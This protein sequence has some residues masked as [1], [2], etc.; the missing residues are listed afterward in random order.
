MTVFTFTKTVL[1]NTAEADALKV[2]LPLSPGILTHA[3][4]NIPFGVQFFC[5]FQILDGLLNV[6]PSR[7]GQYY[8]GEGPPEQIPVWYHLKKEPFELIWKLWNVD[9]TYPHTIVLKLVVLT[10]EEAASLDSL[11]KIIEGLKGLSEVLDKKQLPVL[12]ELVKEMKNLSS[13]LQ[14]TKK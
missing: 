4:V 2:P 13:R 8:T 10:E 14:V 11:R 9:E 12:Q 5:R 1:A 7:E 6:I 3:I